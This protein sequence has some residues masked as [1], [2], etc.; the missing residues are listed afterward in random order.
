MFKPDRDMMA[1]VKMN[2]GYCYRYDTGDSGAEWEIVVLPAGVEDRA[3]AFR[4]EEIDGS[5]CL[6]FKDRRNG[7]DLYAQT[8]ASLGV[9][10]IAVYHQKRCSCHKD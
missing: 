6:V 8:I 3:M 2:P 1:N 9:E 4:A 5:D 10:R 7:R